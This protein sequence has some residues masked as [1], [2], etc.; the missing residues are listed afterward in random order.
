MPRPHAEHKTTRLSVSLDAQTY[1]Q[2][3]ALA[4]RSDV[5]TAWVIRRAVSELIERSKQP[6]ETLELPLHRRPAPQRL[7]R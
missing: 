6:G 2:V 3:R 5:S 1:A 7:E 4:R